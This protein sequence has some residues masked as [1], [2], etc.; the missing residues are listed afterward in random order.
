MN[1][2]GKDHTFDFSVGS[3]QPVLQWAAFFGDCHHQITKVT[4]G[5]RVT[6]TYNILR[7]EK[8]EKEAS[9]GWGF[10]NTHFYPGETKTVST[11]TMF[12]ACL[13][14]HWEAE[15]CYHPVLADRA[16]TS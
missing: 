13:Q 9:Y 1:H 15:S 11:Q 4:S 7:Q 12:V 5:H 2:G 16:D 6:L 10:Y 8:E 14:V 3:T